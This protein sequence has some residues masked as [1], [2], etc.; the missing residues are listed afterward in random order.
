MPMPTITGVAPE[1]WEQLLQILSNMGTDI[2]TITEQGITTYGEL[3]EYMHTQGYEPVYLQTIQETFAG[4]AKVSA[5]DPTTSNEVATTVVTDVAT[6]SGTGTAVS[7]F[8]SGGNRTLGL[9]TKV[10]ALGACLSLLVST[11]GAGMVADDIKEDLIT[12]IDPYTIDGENVPVLIDENGKTH[13]LDEMVEA[14][15]NKAIELGVF[16]TEEEPEEL[17]TGNFTPSSNY[18]DFRSWYTVYVN[19]WKIGANDPFDRFS[20]GFY[21]Y[22]DLI[23]NWFSNNNLNINDYVYFGNWGQTSG[24]IIFLKK[25]VPFNIHTS[26]SGGVT[27][28]YITTP[29]GT[30]ADIQNYIN[31]RYLIGFSLSHSGST[32]VI[33]EMTSSTSF[34]VNVMTFPNATFNPSSDKYGL[35]QDFGTPTNATN[36]PTGS[37]YAAGWYRS[38]NV[39][40][41]GGV[42]GLTPNPDTSS[43]IADITTPLTD[44][45]PQLATGAMSTANP[46]ENDLENKNTWYP[47]SINSSD[48]F[49]DG[50][51]EE[52]TATATDGD[53]KE[54]LQPS[55]MDS[56]KEL[57]EELLR[58]PEDPTEIV[59]PEI[60]V[61]DSGDTPPEDPTL[62][63]GAANGLWTIY[64]PTLAEVQAFG[65]WLWSSSILDQIT[66]MFNS[67]IDAIIGFHQIYCTPITGSSKNIMAGFLDSGVSAAEVTNQYVEIDCGQVSVNEYYGNVL[68][69]LNTR[70]SIFLPFCGFFPLDTAVVMGSTLEVTYRIDVLTGTCLAQVKVIK[71]NSNAVMYS[72]AGN[73]AVQIP[74]TATTYTGMVGA[75]VST[76]SAGASLMTGNML[77]AGASAMRAMTAG[78]TGLS[79][80]RQSGSMGANAG[81]LGIRV[82]YLII[83]H[84]IQ[85]N[86][87][88]FED[89]QGLPANKTVRLGD[90]SG[91]TRVYAC[92]LDAISGATADEIEQLREMLSNGVIL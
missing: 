31:N 42:D 51:T 38:F 60:E 12:S 20:L 25:G 66:R 18:L 3:V 35:Q 61:G 82:P 47:I 52:E 8:T 50:A 74:L 48:V 36:P 83:T 72:F 30:T 17:P 19:T 13:F 88:Y 79:G 22:H 24:N 81:A 65:A 40:P 1:V 85:A 33:T 39:T 5:V 91:F 56:I 27:Y 62:L 77:G 58:D 26:T 16:Q 87:A 45:F 75:L 57:I 86:A 46:T 69:Y 92:H 43:D 70:I 34:N 15:R 80:V 73:C 9:V 71:E 29:L 90:I 32:S 55:I 4:W 68:D 53:V 67:P 44:I 78:M 28:Y 59:Y 41:A 63:S 76:L 10:V 2:A 84:P 49:T 37:K 11:I 89:I 7:T 64:N 21:D 54:D 6:V 14:V 23:V